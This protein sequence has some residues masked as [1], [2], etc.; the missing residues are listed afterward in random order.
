MPA[1][2]RRPTHT[3]L[4]DRS[5]SKSSATS[6]GTLRRG[7]SVTVRMVPPTNAGCRGASAV[8]SS[9]PRPRPGLAQRGRL[10]LDRGLREVAEALPQAHHRTS[11]ISGP[12]SK[13]SRVER[14]TSSSACSAA[15]CGL[16]GGLASRGRPAAA[17][18]AGAIGSTAADH[19]GLAE[20]VESGAAAASSIAARPERT[21]RRNHR[22]SV[23]TE[24]ATP[25]RRPCVRRGPRT[26]SGC[27]ARCRARPRAPRPCRPGSRPPWR[28]RRGSRPRGRRSGAPR[29]PAAAGRTRR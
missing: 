29:T 22:G 28:S 27:A 19:D 14:S 15:G 20:H 6:A 10:V 1:M 7:G 11:V 8:R 17:A 5:P 4:T 12:R 25:A 21:P 3:R 26:A 23:D 13:G 2:L 24:E 16:G 9:P 18:R